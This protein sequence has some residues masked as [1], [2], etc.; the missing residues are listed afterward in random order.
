M[1]ALAA[2]TTTVTGTPSRSPTVILLRKLFGRRIVLVGAAILPSSHWPR[3]A[4]R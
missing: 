4:R 1:D 3:C 2:G